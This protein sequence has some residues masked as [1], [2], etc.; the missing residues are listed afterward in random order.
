MTNT[1]HLVNP[2]IKGDNFPI[3]FNGKNSIQ[4]AKLAYGSISDHF[5][6]KILKFHFTLQK[7][8][9]DKLYHFKVS[10]NRKDDKVNL[11]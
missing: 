2:T 1:Y 5:N 6:N 9:G 8:A 11:H 4:A 7:G 3:S 10:E